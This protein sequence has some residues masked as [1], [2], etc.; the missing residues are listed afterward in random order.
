VKGIFPILSR[1]LP[2]LTAKLVAIAQALDTKIYCD[3]R[4]AAILRC[5]SDPELHTLLTTDP[6]S[7]GVHLVPLSIITSDRLKTYMDRFK[8]S[9]SR[10]IGFRPTG[11][12]YVNS[13]SFLL[14]LR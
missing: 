9:Y 7:A 4:K 11:W 6:L 14:F 1:C 5:Q 3:A 2:T 13:R 12:T 10:A 8:K